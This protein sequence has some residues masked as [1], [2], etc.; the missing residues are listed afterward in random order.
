MNFIDRLINSITIF[1]YDVSFYVMSY[2][3]KEN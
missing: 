3:D 1:I 2:F